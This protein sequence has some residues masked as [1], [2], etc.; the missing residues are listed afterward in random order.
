M[1]MKR[2]FIVAA[3]AA[4]IGLAGCETTGGGV[5]PGKVTEVVTKVQEYTKKACSFVPTAATVNNLLKTF[6]VTSIDGV[7]QMAGEIC[8]VVTKQQARRS[9]SAKG[10]ILRGVRIQGRFVSS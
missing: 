2:M 4:S 5:V 9:R 3:M 7:V 8:A 10:P 6:G 1:L